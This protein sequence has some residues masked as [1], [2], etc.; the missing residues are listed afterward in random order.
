MYIFSFY[1]IWLILFFFL[2]FVLLVVIVIVS[3]CSKY[4]SK[5]KNLL[6]IYEMWSPSRR[7]LQRTPHKR[8]SGGTIGKMGPG[9]LP[10]MS[11]WTVAGGIFVVFV[12]LFIFPPK[13]WSKEHNFR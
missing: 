10:V 4:R 3:L 1:N 6:A 5:E 2:F 9:G 7:V 8:Y 12:C 11:N 13:N